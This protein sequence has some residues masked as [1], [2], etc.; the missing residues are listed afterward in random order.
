MREG[1]KGGKE[2]FQAFFQRS[3][4]F[5]QSEFVEIR[6]T[7]SYKKGGISPKIQRRRFRTKETSYPCYYASRGRDSSYLV[8]FQPYACFKVGLLC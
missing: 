2:S 1:K 5:H 7:H 3:T 4:E 6:T 8:Y